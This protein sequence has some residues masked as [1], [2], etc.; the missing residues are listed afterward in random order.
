MKKLSQNVKFSLLL[1]L[2][3]ATFLLF[4]STEWLIY[5]WL[6]VSK[7][8]DLG[9]KL[10]AIGQTVSNIF[11]KTD[12]LLLDFENIYPFQ[13]SPSYLHIMDNMNKIKKFNNL[14]SI[15]ILN[16]NGEVLLDPDQKYSIG[17][18]YEKLIID[19][20]AWEKSSI[21]ISST[22]DFYNVNDNPY[23]SA[24]IP[25]KDEINRVIAIIKVE[26]NRNYF[27]S[28][29]MMHSFLLWINLTIFLIICLIVLRANEM[30]KK[31]IK[32]EDAMA[33]ADRF[34]SLGTL[35]AGI[36]HELRNPLGIIRATSEVLKSE[37]NNDEHKKLA[38][39]IIEE[40]DRMNDLL[41]NFLHFSK[42]NILTDKKS[43]VLSDVIDSV[44]SLI[45]K[46]L[47]SN[48]KISIDKNDVLK[49]KTK[50]FANEKS[51]KQVLIN[52]VLNASEAINDKDGEIKIVVTD[53]GKYA[54]IKISD[55]GKGIDEKDIKNIYDPFFTTK[56]NGTG[57][58]LTITKSIIESIGGKINI[59]SKKNIGTTVDILLKIISG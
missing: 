47:K 53:D 45:Q 21:G 13:N 26:A 22:S 24:Y 20:N 31:I 12:L 7:E 42:N 3:V 6:K 4:L 25:I 14:R 55:N 36:A 19:S 35:S 49:K 10:I 15:L 29:Y 41:T 57:L 30:V 33:V 39:D 2:L 37:S 44:I 32:A 18:Y 43:I 59:T 54:Q 9:E 11:S 27:N 48:I 40:S 23:K 52:L 46:S 28:L 51:I 56:Q 17:E 38:N 34:R 58:G 8:R 16:K 1:F 50:I 5:Q